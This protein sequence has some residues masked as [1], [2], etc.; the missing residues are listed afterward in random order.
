M[1]RAQ[2]ATYEAPSDGLD[3]RTLPNNL[4]AERS[5]LGA[6]LVHAAAF[7]IAEQYITHAD[8]YRVAHQKIYQR[9]A[10]LFERNI[11]ADFVTLKEE[12]MRTGELEDVGGP[13]YIS[14]LADGVPK[15]TNVTH[16]A[17]I[18]KEKAALRR[19][20]YAASGT[21]TEAYAAEETAEDIVLHAERALVDVAASSR[22][23]HQRS[24]KDTS[25]ERFAALEW[26]YKHKG[27]LRGLDTGYGSINDLTLGWRPGDLI[28]IA[29]R[30]SIG[31]TT[32]VTNTSM[33]SAQQ[34]KRWGIFS[35]EMTREQIDDRVLAM[36]SGVDCHRIQSGILGQADFAKLAP[37]LE[38]MARCDYIVNDRAG[39]TILDIR[40]ACRRIKNEGGIDGIVIDYVQLMPGSLN[41]KGATR[42]EELTDA[43]K[44]AKELGRD[45]NV[46][47]I[48]LSQLRRTEGRPRLDDLRE[49]GG[50]EQA[51]DIVG[52]LHRPDARVS[53]T[54]EFILAKQRNGPTGTVE[55]TIRRD[56]LRFTDGGMPIVEPEPPPAPKRAPKRYNPPYVD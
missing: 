50:L 55:L 9:L 27:Q 15:A 11:A 5:V 42:T 14:A 17:G 39:Q 4:D 53:G 18:V 40:R 43:A 7:E 49:S 12:L 46:P 16:Y 22:D 26:R 33:H 38:V 25:T 8:F 52:L 3:A 2:S 56:I 32:F 35:L 1:R 51:A 44:G 54:T 20:I 24:F 28:I 48:L 37:A 10:A 34:G 6:I 21:L 36:L 19:I 29:A 31:K 23:S 47:V 41:R 13:G 30:T 45:L